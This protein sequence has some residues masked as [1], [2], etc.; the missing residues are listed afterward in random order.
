MESD[1]RE[2]KPEE[3]QKDDEEFEA[4]SDEP[5]E[6]EGEP[7]PPALSLRVSADRMKVLLTWE[8]MPADAE[9]HLDLIRKYL[10]EKGIPQSALGEGLARRFVK[11]IKEA[12]SLHD[13]VLIE[14]K[15][16]GQARDGYIKW[17]GDLFRQGFEVDEKTG[18]VDYRR[19]LAKNAVDAGQLLAT[20]VPPVRGEDGVD[21]YGKV[22][23][24]DKGFFPVITAGQNVQEDGNKVEYHAL[25]PGRARWAGG[26][27]SVDEVLVIE[28]SVGLRTGHITH[29]GALVVKGDIEAESVVEAAGD[30]E[31]YGII[32]RADVDTGGN[33]T[34][35]GGISGKG[36]G[37]IHVAGQVN[38][39]FINEAD[40][41]AG[42]DV[43][44]EREILQSNVKTLGSIAVQQGRLVGGSVMALGGILVGQIGSEAHVQTVLTAGKD[45]KLEARLSGLEEE[46]DA[47]EERRGKLARTLEPMLSQ[48]KQIQKMPKM[49]EAMTK[50]VKTVKVLA[51]E[52][53][54]LDAEIS[55]IQEEMTKLRAQ[56]KASADPRVEISLRIFPD[57]T[58]CI[59]P[60]QIRIK[61]PVSGSTHAVVVN[62]EVRLRRG[63][64]PR[65]SKK[66]DEE[67]QETAAQEEVQTEASPEA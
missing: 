43:V 16:P 29:P 49:T 11:L 64:L 55:R 44:I 46:L 36:N 48:V 26:T 66:T 12:S 56:S 14:G 33:L 54:K 34:V 1:S 51:D 17:A 27:L 50:V 41:E 18:S 25:T 32:E 62:G 63:P 61:E 30:V 4:T 3:Q 39:R 57:T 6:Q 22:V 52:V 23:S 59:P 20:I 10:L 60:D 28:E 37:C 15:P 58:I 19:P 31:V 47:L 45:Y 35:H 65:R 38:A 67:G 2:E 40:I 24:G 7:P 53:K 13:A 9:Q 21:V 5:D 42:K 8:D